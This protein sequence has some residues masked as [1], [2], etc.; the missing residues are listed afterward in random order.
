MPTQTEQAQIK[1]AQRFLALHQGTSPLLMPN[2]WDLGSARLLASLGFAALATTSSGFAATLGQLDG[3][4][5]LDQAIEHS[6]AIAGATELPV[7]ADLENCYAEDLDGVAET[8]R[9]AIGAGL[10]GCSI[11]DYSGGADPV[12]YDRGLAAERV[13]AAVEAAHSGPV[14]LVLTARAENHIRANPDLA[15]TIARLQ[16]YAEAGAD[17]LYAPGVIKPADLRELVASVDRPVNVLALPGV[18]PVSELA[19]IGVKRVSVGGAF[20]FA[21]LGALAEAGRELLERGSY[22]YWELARPGTAAA[23]A[24]FSA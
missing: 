18:P 19:E 16:S 13:A 4:V 12:I 21:A 23:R 9:R 10:A 17:V 7:S 6:A 2:A 11:E 22:S 3:S 8:V 1:N 5:T 15:D 14:H 20:A 24:A